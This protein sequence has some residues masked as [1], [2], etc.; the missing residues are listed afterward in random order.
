V[1]KYQPGGGGQTSRRR[2]KGREFAIPN[3]PIETV[4]ECGRCGGS[5]NLGKGGGRGD[6]GV[7]EF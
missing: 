7:A 6:K 4:D 1:G 5:N 2:K 3:V